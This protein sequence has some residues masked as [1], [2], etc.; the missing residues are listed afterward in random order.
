MVEYFPIMFQNFIIDFDSTFVKCES[1][2]ELARISLQNNPDRDKILQKIDRI[3]KQGMDGTM[4]F[5]RSLEARLRLFQ[6]S[7]R[8]IERLILLLK[9]SITLSFKN[10]K[11]FF[12]KN[13]KKIYIVSGGFKEY[14]VPVLSE[15]G[16][17]DDHIFANT[18]IFKKNGIVAGLDKKNFLAHP[19]GKAKA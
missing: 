2:D 9:K 14:I 17:S 10:N 18:F 13:N 8:D 19:R 3:T 15:F 7:K 12:L 11:D 5:D 1:L 6:S 4:P 16:I